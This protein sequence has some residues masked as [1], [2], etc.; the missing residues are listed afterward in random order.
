MGIPDFS[1][2]AAEIGH[3][4]DP[5]LEIV[6]LQ[7]LLKP[8][9]HGFEVP[10]GEAAV[11]RESFADDEQ[12]LEPPGEFVVGQGDEPADIHQGVLLGA[13]RGP[14]RAGEHL[15]GDV[16]DRPAGEPRL[17]FLDEV[18]VLGEA[19]GIEEEG[20]AVAAADLAHPADVPERGR[21]AAAAVVGDGHHHQRHFAGALPPD[22]PVELLHIHVALEG[23]LRPGVVRFLDG[24]VQGNAPPDLD[25]GPGGIEMDVV[26]HGIALPDHG[27]EEKALRRPSLV[28]RDDMGKAEDRPDRLVKMKIIARPGV[29]FVPEH[30]PGPLVIRHRRGAAIGQKVDEDLLGRDVEDI[31]AGPLQDGLPFAAA[32]PA[33]GFD[34]LDPVGLDGHLRIGHSFLR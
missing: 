13:H 33:D 4:T 23:N 12:V 31:E 28:G 34:D 27:F 6:L 1:K 19:A 8:P 20:D 21:L 24:Q 26:G 18:G 5:V 32:C 14:V 3:L 7:D 16:E 30:D 25:V 11:G 9:G 10:A 22:E 15:A 29:G 2:E 17:P